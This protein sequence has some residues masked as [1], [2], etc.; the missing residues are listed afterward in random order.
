H[1]VLMESPVAE[2]AKVATKLPDDSELKE[3]FYPIMC[4]FHNTEPTE[5]TKNSIA[6]SA[7]EVE[8]DMAVLEI[9]ISF[10]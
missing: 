3:L 2:I 10:K 1:Q 4:F 5:Q 8:F 6:A 7:I 9:L